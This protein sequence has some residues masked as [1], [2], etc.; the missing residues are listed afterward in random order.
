M[1]RE[2]KWREGEITVLSGWEVKIITSRGVDLY[3][4]GERAGGQV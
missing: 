2:A 1:P 4:G 3:R